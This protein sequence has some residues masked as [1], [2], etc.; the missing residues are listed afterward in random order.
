MVLAKLLSYVAKIL[1][2]PAGH[3]YA[4]MESL[5]VLSWLK[6][7]P[8]QFKM[9]VGNRVSEIVEL[10]PT[11]SWHYI[12][13][14]NNPADCASKDLFPTTLAG[15]SLWWN[16]PDWLK[17]PDSRWPSSPTLV[18]QSEPIEERE[19]PPETSLVVQTELPLVE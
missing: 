12:E 9:F 1:D 8:L 2:I 16:G 15:H 5:V 19:V 3:T 14:C 7:N 4:W 17:G 13:S 6:G 18:H 10:T 11:T